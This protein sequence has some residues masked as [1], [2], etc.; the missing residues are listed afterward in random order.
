MQLSLPE[1]V[2]LM[3]MNEIEALNNKIADQEVLLQEKDDE[4]ENSKNNNSA[5]EKK[6]L[7]DHEALME[8]HSAEKAKL[9]KRL[10][11]SDMLAKF[12]AKVLK[13]N[14]QAM[15][16]HQTTITNQA[17]KLRTTQTEKEAYKT[18]YLT[19]KN[20]LETQTNIVQNQSELIQTLR[21]VILHEQALNKTCHALQSSMK[22]CNIPSYIGSMTTALTD[23]EKEIQNL[24]IA[25]DK[26]AGVEE[27]LEKITTGLSKLNKTTA[28]N[29]K[30]T[31][32]LNYQQV[33]K[34]QSKSIALMKTMLSYP[35]TNGSS[36]LRYK[37]D[38]SG[39]LVSAATCQCVPEV[40]EGGQVS[41]VLAQRNGSLAP[42]WTEWHYD[43]ESWPEHPQP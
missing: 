32:L 23:Q 17:D 5:L 42:M 19:T 21:S 34:L 3:K 4:I 7:V 38:R 27:N 31:L 40:E 43:G 13:H 8:K 28:D 9:E 18:K 14:D 26:T 35:T 1:A 36:P 25:L 16:E 30:W 22:T 11:D 12:L 15:T 33:L 37:S 6:H 29:S 24:K 41:A 2:Q 10:A 20:L 39:N